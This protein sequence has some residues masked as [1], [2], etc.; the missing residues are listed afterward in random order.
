MLRQNG[1]MDILK[2][3]IRKEG[4]FALYKGMEAHRFLLVEV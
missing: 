4:F 2:Q 3:T 1:P